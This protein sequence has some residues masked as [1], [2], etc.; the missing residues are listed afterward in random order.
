MHQYDFP[1]LNTFQTFNKRFKCN[2]E[3][4]KLE[5][6]TNE[7][8]QCEKD[9][10]EGFVKPKTKEQQEEEELKKLA[11]QYDYDYSDD[12]EYDEDEEDVYVMVSDLK[13]EKAYGWEKCV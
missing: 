2:T 11:E 7:K 13:K 8:V 10:C 9:F 6:G 4:R 12:E 5:D 3:C 1:C